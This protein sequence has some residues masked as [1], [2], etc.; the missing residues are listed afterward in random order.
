MHL[1]RAEIDLALFKNSQPMTRRRRIVESLS[2]LVLPF[3]LS[4]VPP[5]GQVTRVLA[6]V[7]GSL[8]CVDTLWWWT[9]DDPLELLKDLFL[10]SLFF[11]FFVTNF[12][13][14]PS[15]VSISM[16]IIIHYFNLS[17]LS[18][19]IFLCFYL[20]FWKRTWEFLFVVTTIFFNLQFYFKVYILPGLFFI[21]LDGLLANPDP[22]NRGKFFWITKFSYNNFHCS[23]LIFFFTKLILSF[24]LSPSPSLL[25]IFQR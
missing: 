2:L 8:C 16:L 10:C 19:L 25:K 6:A 14:L 22:T 18:F 3:V 4:L 21:K 12:L 17:F 15:V 20:I 23:L 1:F 9:I 5:G 11:T 24:F 13:L 7:T